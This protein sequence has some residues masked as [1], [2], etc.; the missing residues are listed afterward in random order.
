MSRPKKPAPVVEQRALD[1][2]EEAWVR[3]LVEDAVQ[4]LKDERREAR[5]VGD[6]KGKAA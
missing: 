5:E 4:Q 1:P 6:R 3:S 2:D